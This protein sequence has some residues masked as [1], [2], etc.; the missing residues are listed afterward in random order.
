MTPNKQLYS[1]IDMYTRP[2]VHVFS[3]GGGEKAAETKNQTCWNPTWP[4]QHLP[5]GESQDTRMH[6]ASQ[7]ALLELSGLA[8]LP[9]T[10]HYRHVVKSK[11]NQLNIRR[12]TTSDIEGNN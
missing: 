7:M 6:I 2:I 4:I 12:G 11:Y 1:P 5:L 10:R 9:V 3:I 8:D